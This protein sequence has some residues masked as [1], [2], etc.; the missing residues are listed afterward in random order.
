MEKKRPKIVMLCSYSASSFY[1]YNGIKDDIDIELVI[2]EKPHS[3]VDKINKKI[4]LTKNRIKRLGVSTVFGQVL[5]KIFENFYIK[6]TSE[7]IILDTKK[8]YQLDDAVPHIENKKNVGSVKDIK[9]INYIEEIR[10]D[11]VLVNGTGILP[12]L[13]IDGIKCPIINTHVGITPK[14]RGS[15]GGYWA[16]ANGDDENFGVTVHLIDQG[17]D[18]GGIL[19]QARGEVSRDNTFTTY[20]LHQIGMAIPL[21]KKALH[22]AMNN[23]IEIKDNNLNSLIWSHPT[24]FEYISNWKTKGVK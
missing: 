10:P 14:Y 4:K 23:C 16:L 7:R 17:I 5:F 6:K 11:A 24:L 8:K 19:Y 15:H 13:V 2:F 9:I 3:S 22:D 18:T 1:V 21:I 12:P 20:P